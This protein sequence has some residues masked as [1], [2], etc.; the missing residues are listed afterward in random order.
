[1]KKDTTEQLDLFRRRQGEADK[2]ILEEGGATEEGTGEGQAGN[3]TTE[4][5]T[6]AVNARKRKRAK[7]KEGLKGLKLRKSSSTAERPSELESER[8][9]STSLEADK[10]T[11][12]ALGGETVSAKAAKDKAASE[13][14]VSPPNQSDKAPAPASTKQ[15]N[16][17]SPTSTGT[18]RLGLTGYSSDEDD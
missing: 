11:T 15:G 14:V 10:K 13:T 3:P 8:R 6:W 4:T 16:G 7:E 18:A 2:A 17:A 5:S 9:G 12:S 1:M